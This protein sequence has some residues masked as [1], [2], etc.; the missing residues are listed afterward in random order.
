M[1]LKVT[2]TFVLGIQ[3]LCSLLF[4]MIESDQIFIDLLKNDPD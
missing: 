2:S 3:R 1:P 4:D